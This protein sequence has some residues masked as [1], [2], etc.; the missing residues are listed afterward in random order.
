MRKGVC[1]KCMKSGYLTEH[2]VFPKRFFGKRNNDSI[3]LLCRKCHDKIELLIPYSDKLTQ[4]EYTEIHKAWMLG[5]NPIVLYKKKQIK[6]FQ[7][8]PVRLNYRQ[9]QRR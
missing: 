3:L 5:K 4:E 6:V 1:P 7:S 2:H 8:S 9:H